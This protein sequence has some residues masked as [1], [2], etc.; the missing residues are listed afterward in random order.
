MAE[1]LSS[2]ARF[3]V[4]R[5]SSN[6]RELLPRGGA[7]LAA[8]SPYGVIIFGGADRGQSHFNDMAILQR[9]KRDWRKR[10]GKGDLPTPRSGHAAVCYGKYMFLFGGIDFTEEAA[11]NDL[12]IL[13]MVTLEW[14]YVG[15]SGVEIPAR[16]SHSLGI[17]YGADGRNHIV[18]YGGASPD[19]GPLGETYFAALPEMDVIGECASKTLPPRGTQT[20]PSSSS[21]THTHALSLYY[22]SVL[23]VL[24]YVAR[25]AE[26]CV[27]SCGKGNAFDLCFA[28]WR[29]N[30][31]WWPRRTRSG[32]KRRVGTRINGRGRRT[33]CWFGVA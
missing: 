30:N 12:Y 6:V 4:T 24:S 33:A 8:S 22:L 32:T 17:L 29:H 14:R 1:M 15:E 26:F 16:N 31:R 25:D 21:P 2:V 23:R 9:N 28:W 11:Y 19:L 3:S 7:S 13:D 27:G 18:I 5:A 10:V 20:H